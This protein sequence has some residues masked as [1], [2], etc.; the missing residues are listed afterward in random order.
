MLMSDIICKQRLLYKQKIGE[1]L[2][3]RKC[4]GVYQ[5]HFRKPLHS[6][7]KT[8]KR[9][10]LGGSV[11]FSRAVQLQQFVTLKLLLLWY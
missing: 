4:Y 9:I 11:Y 6:Y 1:Y 2:Q 8:V 3:N 10:A 5:G 7:K